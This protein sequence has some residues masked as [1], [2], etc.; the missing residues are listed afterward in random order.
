MVRKYPSELRRIPDTIEWAFDQ[1]VTR[2]SHTLLR[3]FRTHNL[4][5]VGS[6]GS[7]VA[8]A[9]AALLHETVTGRL[10]R[11]TTPLE[12]ISRHPPLNTSALL[13]SA[14]GSNTDI[15]RAAEM[16]PELGYFPVSAITARGGSQMSR[17]LKGY[18]ATVHEFEVPGGRD[19]FLATNSLIATLML[20]YRAAF[21][22]DCISGTQGNLALMPPTFSGTKEV[23][24]NRTLVVLAQGWA[25]PA[26]LDLESRFAEAAIAN[27]TVT[28]ARNFAHGRHHWLS[29]YANETGIVSLETPSSADVAE[30]TLRL[31][32]NETRILRVISPHD[33]PAASIELIRATMEFAWD[34]A[35]SMGFDPG[36][37]GVAE[38]GKR[39]YRARVAPTVDSGES[40]S[41][42]RKRR[43]F[44]LNPTSK[45][46]VLI[47]ARN[48]FLRRLADTLFNG[49]VVDYDG[50][51]CAND[52][53]FDPLEQDISAELTRLLDEGA[54]V[55]VASGR[56]GSVYEELRVALGAQ[57]WDRVVIGCYN[58]AITV[59]LSDDLPTTLGE[60]PKPLLLAK[61][62]LRQA[63]AVLGF[64]T[65][66]RPPQISIRPQDGVGA[67]E[68][69]GIIAE[70]LA[71]I[72]GLKTV[73]SSHSVDVIT[74]ETTKMTVV[75]VLDE[76]V[77]GS[78]LRIGDQG[79]IGGNDFELLNT[80]LS[81]S[82]DRVSS[83]LVA[84]WN[85]GRPGV[86]GPSLTLQYLRALYR[87]PDG[88]RFDTSLFIDN[89]GDGL[90]ES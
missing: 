14:R 71:G 77:G 3:E 35:N 89:A 46:N 58:G 2:L 51:L 16:M 41:T 19:G 49:V 85:L 76:F 68:L 45:Q 29:R 8:A 65:V 83:N 17:I 78:L 53:R 44:Y 80:G 1:D 21:P 15:V 47:R 86:S 27:V 12:A 42:A 90:H 10:A 40:E 72:P 18:G 37:P 82:V 74:T 39:L 55:G 84:C 73:A 25:V 26:A 88:F 56:G 22:A 31:F 34:I 79:A 50:T 52:R 63:E 81:L 59:R 70:Q 48:V 11:A 28:D 62:R 5:A 57:Y 6:G 66:V 24:H 60:T 13:L 30:R 9:F 87:E 64:Q 61:S 20:L 69:Q 43:A 4:I 54:V 75:D 7:Q 38:F 36:R 23:L 33:G 67:P 32:P